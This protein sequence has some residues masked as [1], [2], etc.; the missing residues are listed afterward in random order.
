MMTGFTH[1]NDLDGDMGGPWKIWEKKDDDR[2]RTLIPGTK[3][4]RQSAK[5]RQEFREYRRI[6]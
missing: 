6:R 1:G 3:K 2:Y 5:S 4:D